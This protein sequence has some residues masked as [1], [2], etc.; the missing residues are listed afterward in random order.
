[1]APR[2]KLK[3]IID[4]L[5]FQIDEGSLYLMLLQGKCIWLTLLTPAIESLDPTP[6][7]CVSLSHLVYG[8]IP[9]ATDSV[10]AT[11]QACFT[12]Q[13]AGGMRAALC[14]GRDA[15]PRRPPAARSA[16]A[17]YHKWPTR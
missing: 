9:V 4:E 16:N 8:P 1:M 5:S 15:S 13:R 3:G 10:A 7:A 12:G 14:G 2:V 17:L 11:P 6:P